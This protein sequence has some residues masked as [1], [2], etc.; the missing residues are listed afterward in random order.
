MSYPDWFKSP[1]KHDLPIPVSKLIKL[2]TIVLVIVLSY[3]SG[4][5]EV[6]NAMAMN[7]QTLEETVKKEGT[8]NLEK[9]IR[10]LAYEKNNTNRYYQGNQIRQVFIGEKVFTEPAQDRNKE[11]NE[12]EIEKDVWGVATKIGEHTYTMQVQP[13]NAMASPQ[14]IF[15]ALNR[16]RKQH[17]RG[18]LSWDEKLADFAQQRTDYFSETGNLDSHKGFTDFLNNQDGFKKLGFIVVGENSSIGFTLS[19]V[20]II[21]WV[22]AGDEEHNSNQL[23]SEWEYVGIGVSDTA[24]DVVFA[25]NRM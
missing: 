19:G 20:H 3:F 23:S 6:L 16:Y 15:N 21:E 11:V 17:G 9:K 1:T 10:E 12:Q 25:A 13:D 4:K 14:D 5:I 2:A 7:G 8:L 22:Y 18:E 24:T